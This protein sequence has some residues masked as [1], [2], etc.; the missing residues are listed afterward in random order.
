MMSGMSW[1][2]EIDIEIEEAQ[3]SRRGGNEGRARVS[4]RRAAGKAIFAMRRHVLGSKENRF[5]AIT[6][7]R[8]FQ[9]FKG[10]TKE[11]QKAAERL[12]VHVNTEH[13]LPHDQD[14][15][16]DALMIIAFVRDAIAK[17]TSI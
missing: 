15:I 11:L 8:W 16:Q 6:M 14:P 7:L 12:T 13:D 1:D 5:G 10:T 2:V 3:A 17:Q 4:A 9:D